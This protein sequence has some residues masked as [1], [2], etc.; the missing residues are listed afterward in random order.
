M[1]HG[2]TMVAS[3]PTGVQLLNLLVNN[4]FTYQIPTIP[5]NQ[6]YSHQK[7]QQY[8]DNKWFLMAQKRRPNTDLIESL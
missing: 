6:Q 4:I 1:Y 8:S 3:N 7:R 2:V 5:P